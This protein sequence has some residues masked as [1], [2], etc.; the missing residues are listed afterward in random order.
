MSITFPYSL[1][2]AMKRFLII[3][4][5]IGLF[6]LSLH[7]VPFT[8]AQ[9][10]GATQS[11]ADQIKQLQNE[12][13]KVLT[14]LVQIMTKLYERG[15]N[16]IEFNQVI[17]AKI[18]L[19][20]AQLDMTDNLKERIALLEDQ[21]KQA[22][23]MLDITEQRVRAATSS[24]VDLL[25]AKSFYLKSQIALLKERQKLKAASGPNQ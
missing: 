24:E 13:V 19:I 10:T 21:L 25:S 22:K 17:S 7:M 14:N 11:D 2:D 18:D 4:I 16:N 8:T 23:I 20:N 9:Q 15:I 3:V 6:V 5:W 1:E 12:R